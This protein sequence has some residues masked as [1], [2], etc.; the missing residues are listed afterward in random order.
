[1]MSQNAIFELCT[2]RE[3]AQLQQRG[4]MPTTEGK[5]A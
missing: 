1:M 5:Q 2:D 3:A 4:V